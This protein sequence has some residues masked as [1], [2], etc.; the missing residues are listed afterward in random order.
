MTRSTIRARFAAVT[1][2]LLLLAATG[3]GD[4]EESPPLAV[5]PFDAQEAR[6]HQHAWA[7]RLGVPVETTNSIGMKL[8]LIPPGEFL[9]GS[10]DSERGRFPNEGTQHR[11]RLTRSFYL[12]THEVTVG[13]F[14][15]FAEDTG[16]VVE[17]DSS[18]GRA[19]RIPP[20]H[21]QKNDHPVARV[22]W[23]D[24]V[25][26]CRWM[27]EKEDRTYRLPTE[28][29]WEYACRA[30]T[31]TRFQFGHDAERLVDFANVA[32]A[33]ARQKYPQWTWAVA[34]KDGYVYT[35]PVGSF[36]A[37]AFGL[38][39]MHGNVAEWCADWYADRYPSY[40][41]TSVDDPVGP[42]SGN[43]RVVRGG[44]WYSGLYRAR[45]TSRNNGPPSWH[46]T[47]WGFRVVLILRDK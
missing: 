3:M 27:S 1:V 28:A 46:R 40:P 2:G 30:G 36:K 14:R 12:G 45:S 47:D 6:A 34:A 29:E 42:Q 22:S 9:M 43:D 24:A 18:D 21:N 39:D 31:T 20:W 32:D 8:V 11:V 17:A 37:N 33:T 44:S 41:A 15:Q 23:N 4:E 5:S 35:A 13:Q 16:Y 19:P 25:G 7:K 26:F 38:H 10:P